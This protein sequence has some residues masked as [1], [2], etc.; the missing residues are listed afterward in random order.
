MFIPGWI[1]ALL[2]FPGVIIHEFAHKIACD[3]TNVRVYRVCYFQIGN[4]AGY[5]EHEPPWK[6]SQAFTITVAPFLV[7][8]IV[9]ILIFALALKTPLNMEIYGIKLR[10]IL[11]WLGISI[12]MHAFPSSHDAKNLWNF[13]KKVWRGNPLVILGIPIVVLIYIADAL[14]YI[15]FDAIYAL[16]LLTL[17]V[18]IV[19]TPAA[20]EITSLARNISRVVTSFAKDVVKELK[21]L[22]KAINFNQVILQN[23][24]PYLLAIFIAVIAISYLAITKIRKKKRYK[25]TDKFEVVYHP[26]TTK[27]KEPLYT[28]C[29]Y[30]GKIVYLPYKCKYCSQYF[31][32]DHR[33]PTRHNCPGLDEYK[34]T[35]PP[36]GG[37]WRYRRRYD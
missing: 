29:A 10:Y 19:K 24:N 31:C 22:L 20:D 4:P 14:R 2:T 27:E 9:A 34:G 13:T 16:I 5:V 37:L 26:D 8:S 23:L 25:V 17:T 7:N 15:W 1:I 12:G 3:M 33:L 32:D 35:P 18:S 36:S 6:Y 28:R 21:I 11:Y 30:C